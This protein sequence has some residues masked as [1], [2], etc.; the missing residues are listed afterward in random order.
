MR[1]FAS[2]V[3]ILYRGRI[4]ETGA[5]GAVFD[6]PQHDYTRLLL[7][8]VPVI[9]AEEEA[10]RPKIPLI[11]GELPTAEELLALRDQNRSMT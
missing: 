10:M 6:A 5:T 7:A 1:N 8:S 2:R 11:N 3:G 9:S 4:V